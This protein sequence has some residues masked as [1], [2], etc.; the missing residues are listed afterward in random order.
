M[1][2]V[3]DNG[4]HQTNPNLRK[5]AIVL[6][7]LP[8]DD[9]AQL[10]GRMSPKEVELVCIEIAHLDRLTGTDQEA[11]IL[12]FAEQNPNQLAGAGGGIGLAK[13]L[14][15]RALGKGANETLDNVRQSVESIPFG[16]L[17]K[18]DSQNLLT[19]IVDEHP[20]TIALILSHLPASYG[21]EI[22][23]GLPADRQLSVIR[24]IAN[25]GQTNPEVIEEVEKGLE[26]RMASVMSQSFENAGG[27]PTVAEILNVTDRA[28]ERALLEHLAQ[29]DPDLVEEIR[30]LMFVF[31]DIQKLSDKDMQAVLKNVESSQWAMALKGASQELRDKVVGNMSKRAADML[32]EEMDFLGAVKVSEVEGVQQQIVDIVRRLEDAGEI[33]LSA[34]DEEEQLVQ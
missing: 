16:F 20:Q 18:V 17:R 10:M 21:A 12:S 33:S 26:S 11:A 9:A 27:V 31:D 7:S 22:I 13:N 5:A 24:R 4:S 8:E 6:M 3:R 23:S 29:E 15:T 14:V 25:M 30:R 2:K 28:T 19:F 34:G 32:L 1:P